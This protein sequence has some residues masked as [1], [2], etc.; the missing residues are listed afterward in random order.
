M[1]KS[2]EAAQTA[3]AI[4][5]YQD[6]ARTIQ[7]LLDRITA[8][9]GLKLQMD[10]RQALMTQLGGDRLASRGEIEKLCLY[11]QGREAITLEDVEMIVG[12]VSDKPIGAAIDAVLLGNSSSLDKSLNQLFAS[13]T[14][15]FVLISSLMREFKS[16][17]AMRA[18]V[19]HGR[20]T[21]S[22]VSAAR[23]PVFFKRKDLVTQALNVWSS[24]A[25]GR[26]LMRI[27]NAILDSR[28]KGAPEESITRNLFLALTVETARGL[29]RNRRH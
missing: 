15:P 14:V 28:Q 25:L 3:A 20:S 26:A 22:V 8:E 11:A 29:K 23:P 6:D 2:V 17:A 24:D 9:F 16:L 5:C 27:E 7:N 19:D 13:K 1:R 10:A 21:S 4:A 18:M 12:D